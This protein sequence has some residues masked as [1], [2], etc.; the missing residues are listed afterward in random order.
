M[1][2]QN[3]LSIVETHLYYHKGTPVEDVC[4]LGFKGNDNLTLLFLDTY[5]E[6]I[7]KV[8][9]HAKNN[10]LFKHTNF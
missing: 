6:K 8:Y 2:Y 7:R 9:E 3:V 4:D 10:K 1:I 5:I